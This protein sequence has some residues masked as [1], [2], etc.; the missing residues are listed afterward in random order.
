M[1]AAN[2]LQ[3]ETEGVTV[4]GS[5]F[6]SGLFLGLKFNLSKPRRRV[7]GDLLIPDLNGPR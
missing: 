6:N 4:R 5:E 7:G 3:L 2:I 1:L